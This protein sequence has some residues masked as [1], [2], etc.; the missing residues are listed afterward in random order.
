[1]KIKAKTPTYNV[2]TQ[3][4]HDEVQ[5]IVNGEVSYLPVGALTKI[6]DALSIIEK[7]EHYKAVLS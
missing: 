2:H 6:I 5:V 1:M 7:N 4:W 3:I